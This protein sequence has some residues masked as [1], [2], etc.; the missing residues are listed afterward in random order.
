VPWYDICKGQNAHKLHVTFSKIL[1]PLNL[2]GLFMPFVRADSLETKKI[3]AKTWS[4]SFTR[5]KVCLP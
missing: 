1:M 3:S 4:C 2:L 5:S